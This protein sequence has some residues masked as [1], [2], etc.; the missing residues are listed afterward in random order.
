MYDPTLLIQNSLLVRPLMQFLWGGG[1]D[2][3]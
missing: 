1:G 3:Y 2:L